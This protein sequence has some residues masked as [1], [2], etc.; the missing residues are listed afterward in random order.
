MAATEGAFMSKIIAVTSGKGGTGKSS[1]CSGLGYALAK[2]GHRTIIIEL[3]FGLR[4]LDI[5]LGVKNDITYDLGS[6][7][8]GKCD[9]YKATTQVRMA[10]NLS[11]V[12]APEDPFAQL[13]AEQIKNICQEM[14]K[15]YEYIIV[16]TSAGIS[17]SV[18][19][20]VEQSDLILIVTTPD[21]ICVRD[22]R[23]MSDEFYKRGNK[24]QRLIINKMNRV[25]FG[26]ELVSDLDEIIDT[27]GVQLIGVIPDDDAVT[28]ATGK[29]EPIPSKSE[30]FIAFDAISKRIKGED[31]PLTVKIG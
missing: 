21:P 18:F 13:E 8:D 30:A 9:I 6:V 10:S 15:Y 16:D 5:M 31:I 2:Q 29:G 19:D 11:I 12:C 20:I 3:D 27:V 1:I 7:L 24:K 22:G 23:T 14:R 4:C 25:I 28:I 17:S 26:E